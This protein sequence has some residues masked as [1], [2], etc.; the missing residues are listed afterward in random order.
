MFEKMT[1][2]P[3]CGDPF[4]Q[5][6]ADIP[7]LTSSDILSW[8]SQDGTRCFQLMMTENP[9]LFKIWIKNWSDLVEFE[10]VPLRESP[11]KILNN[12]DTTSIWS[13]I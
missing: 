1:S 13:S 4:T 8:L 12:E 11:A 3:L 10:I 5:G 6:G 7:P 9:K 2:T